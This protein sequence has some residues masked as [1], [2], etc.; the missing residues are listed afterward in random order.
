MEKKEKQIEMFYIKIYN[1]L[2]RFFKMSK[3]L[4]LS[5]STLITFIATYFVCMHIR[6]IRCSCGFYGIDSPL[7]GSDTCYV[8]MP[9]QS[10]LVV[11]LSVSILVIAIMFPRGYKYSNLV[12]IICFILFAVLLGYVFLTLSSY[13][14]TLEIS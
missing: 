6:P 12:R 8:G 5:I 9:T 1:N 14:S 13:C 7:T 3:W 10:M 11:A 2:V 4:K